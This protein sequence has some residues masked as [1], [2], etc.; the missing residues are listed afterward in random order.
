MEFY[1]Q[2]H[3]VKFQQILKLIQEF[4]DRTGIKKYVLLDSGASASIVHKDILYERH[5]NHKDKKNKW[6]TMAGTFNTT[7]VT[8]II[9]K[10]LELNH[11][12]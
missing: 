11:S 12:A 7:F 5:R 6:S 8:E 2:I 10:L 4:W 3:A 1:H 9:L